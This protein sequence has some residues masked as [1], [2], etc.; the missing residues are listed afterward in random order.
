MIISLH[1]LGFVR[2]SLANAH[3]FILSSSFNI[4]IFFNHFRVLSSTYF[5]SEISGEGSLRLFNIIMKMIG[6]N[7]VS[8]GSQAVTG[9]YCEMVDPI[10]TDFFGIMMLFVVDLVECFTKVKG[11]LDI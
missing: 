1:L 2:V 7:L 6:P 10:F 4:F 3:E 5:Q 8:C 9:S 11:P